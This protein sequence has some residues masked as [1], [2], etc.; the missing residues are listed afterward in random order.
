MLNLP[1]MP[2]CYCNSNIMYRY[3][4]YSPGNTNLV[5]TVP[6][7]GQTKLASIPI[8]Q[9]VT[10]H[11]FV[12]DIGMKMLI[13]PNCFRVV[14]MFLGVFATT[15]AVRTAKNLSSARQA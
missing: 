2:L 13:H 5:F 12:V 6:H 7:D 11:I 10:V 1:C 15:Q 4:E 14:G 3:V 8:R 9:N